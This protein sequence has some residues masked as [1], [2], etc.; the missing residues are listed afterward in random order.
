M[1]FLTMYAQLYY[2]ISLTAFSFHPNEITQMGQRSVWG[3]VQ[4]GGLKS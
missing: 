3:I 1:K 2:K 4:L